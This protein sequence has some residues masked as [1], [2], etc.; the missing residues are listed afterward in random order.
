MLQNFCES[1]ALQSE[2]KVEEIKKIKSLRI[3]NPP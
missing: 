1:I 2:E 3:G